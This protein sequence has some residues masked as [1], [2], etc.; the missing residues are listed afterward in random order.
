MLIN[1]KTFRQKSPE[2][3]AL[4]ATTAHYLLYAYKTLKDVDLKAGIEKVIDRELEA[5]AAEH[6]AEFKVKAYVV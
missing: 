2:A 1:K 3:V 4:I 5:I 6:E